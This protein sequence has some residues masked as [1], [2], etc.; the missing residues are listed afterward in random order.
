VSRPSS[1]R[2]MRKMGAGAWAAQLVLPHFC[3][4]CR[5]TREGS[6]FVVTPTDLRVGGV[7]EVV[8]VLVRI[9]TLTKG[10]ES[11]TGRGLTDYT[12][13]ATH[14]ATVGPSSLVG[15]QGEPPLEDGRMIRRRGAGTM[16]GF[17]ASPTLARPAAM[18][19]RSN[20]RSRSSW[21]WMPC[22]RLL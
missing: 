12:G 6:F 16:S 1:P 17:R 2:V 7:R 9:G 11:G 5:T 21:G 15:E 14:E 20:G 19:W 22:T 10:K 8:V 4:A 3:L 18:S 13:V